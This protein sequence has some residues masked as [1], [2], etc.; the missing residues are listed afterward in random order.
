MKKNESRSRPKLSFASR[1]NVTTKQKTKAELTR[2]LTL[3]KHV[4]TIRNKEV[5][6]FKGKNVVLPKIPKSVKLPDSWSETKTKIINRIRLRT[7]K[8]RK[9]NVSAFFKSQ[10]EN[11]F[12]KNQQKHSLNVYTTRA[13]FDNL[14]LLRDKS[15]MRKFNEKRKVKINTNKLKKNLLFANLGY[16]LKRSKKSRF[17]RRKYIQY[18]SKSVHAKRPKASIH[19]T[20]REEVFPLKGYD[21][22]PT[23]GFIKK[24]HDKKMFKSLQNNKVC[25]WKEKPGPKNIL[26]DYFL[27]YQ[28][29]LNT[30]DENE[31]RRS[32]NEQL[33]IRKE[34][35][36]LLNKKRKDRHM[37][38]QFYFKKSKKPFFFKK[39]RS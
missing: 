32:I 8:K 28:D 14:E 17:V 16:R 38:Y 33:M 24:K 11:T 3:R 21:F 1:Q 12:R 7:Q 26:R 19:K 13:V 34:F 27:K 29:T 36:K 9:S 37:F 30:N 15:F 2:I 35:S 10:E 4:Q 22:D 6:Y 25:H 18:Y 31:L 39:K 20:K 5:I 23:N